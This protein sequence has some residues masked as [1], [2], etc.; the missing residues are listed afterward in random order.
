MILAKTD[1][2]TIF[3]KIHYTYLTTPMDIMYGMYKQNS[4]KND[5]LYINLHNVFIRGHRGQCRPLKFT[6]GKKLA[7]PPKNRFCS[8]YTQT[9]IKSHIGYVRLITDVIGGYYRS[10]KIKSWFSKEVEKYVPKYFF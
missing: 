2:A 10:H 9:S 4:F 1:Y 7:T 3:I 6:R 8:I 5:N